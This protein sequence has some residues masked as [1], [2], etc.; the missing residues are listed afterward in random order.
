MRLALFGGTFDPIHDA[1]LAIARAAAEQFRL[2]RVL[3][4]PA[5]HP[6]HKAG[7]THASYEDRVRM[8]ELACAGRASPG[9]IACLE[10]GT[11]RSYSIDTIEKVRARMAPDQDQRIL[12]HRRRRLRRDP[13]LAALARRGPR[14][15]VPGDQPPRPRL[16][17]AAGSPHG[18][19]GHSGVTDLFLAYSRG[20]GRRAQSGRRSET[21]TRLHR[22]PRIIRGAY[23]GVAPAGKRRRRRRY[24][25]RYAAYVRGICRTS[26]T[27]R[28][29]VHISAQLRAASAGRTAWRTPS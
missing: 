7:V 1:H 8:A 5:A 26:K 28:V 20:P 27:G 2:D 23:S 13:H 9:G 22:A 3:L 16:R 19:L 29:A 15:G 12:H 21:G 10:E 24:S 14:G 18:A 25:N 4:V 6:P 11:A 17:R